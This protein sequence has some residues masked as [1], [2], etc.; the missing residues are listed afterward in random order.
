MPKN[1]KTTIA[2]ALAGVFGAVAQA[3]PNHAAWAQPA[4]SALMALGGM[5]AQDAANSRG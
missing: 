4:S 5:F 1:W 2:F 3:A